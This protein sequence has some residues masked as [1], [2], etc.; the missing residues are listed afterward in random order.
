MSLK[1]ISRETLRALKAEADNK[2]RSDQ[3]AYVVKQIYMATE[4]AARTSDKTSFLW[5]IYEGMGATHFTQ[6]VRYD[7]DHRYISA[8]KQ[9]LIFYITNMN[10]I[11]YS[12]RTLFPDCSVDHKR[13]A[14]Q[15][16]GTLREISS[17][18]EAEMA[19]AM[20]IDV[21]VID[22]S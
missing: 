7:N 15:I 11:I 22:W 20:T 8:E 12:L 4:L 17:M 18:T 5:P 1:P 16:D 3:L 13:M 14:R 6:Y 2:I 19:I 10:D 9:Q 21:I